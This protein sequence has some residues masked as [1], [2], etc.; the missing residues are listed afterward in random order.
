MPGVDMTEQYGDQVIRPVLSFPQ[1]Y[2]VHT[3][4]KYIWLD[5]GT[6]DSIIA[7]LDFT[8][9]N[10]VLVNLA[11]SNFSVRQW[12][13]TT[14]FFD[15]N[16]TLASDLVINSISKILANLIENGEYGGG[17]AE[18]Q[19]A[20]KKEL[21]EMLKLANNQSENM[22]NEELLTMLPTLL[23][24]F[25]VD[26]KTGVDELSEMNILTSN[27]AAQL[28]KLASLISNPKHLE[29]IFPYATADGKQNT[30]TSEVLMVSNSNLVKVPAKK[31]RVLR[32]RIDMDT[33][34]SRI[35]KKEREDKMIDVNY[36]YSVAMQQESFSI[37]MTTLGIPE[38]DDPA[39]EYLS[40]RVC[41]KFYD[42]RLANGSLHWLSGVYQITSF[43]H[44]I[45]PSQGFL[46]EL[47]M[48]R[49]PNTSLDN[50]IDT[51]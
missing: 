7:D 6:P 24:S 1:T 10:R 43:K 28:R 48:I 21:G 9:D 50:I 30:V 18:E 8:G 39:S 35:S 47:E 11:Q 42:P 46:T 14:Q 36:N 12:N 17:T 41:F 26:S 51:R 31:T 37:S 15:G 3:G 44:R 32:R 23:P 4:P 19:A 40:R 22:I 16:E 13:D 45:N 34:R 25:Q 29:M 38:I 2:S 5:Y 20:R 27:D 49:I 33:I